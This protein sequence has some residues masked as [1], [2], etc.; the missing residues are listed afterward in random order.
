MTGAAGAPVVDGVLFDVD[1]TLV[2]TR[3]AFGEAVA[4]VRREFLPHVPAAR[5]P[6][7]LAV[8]R[9]DVHGHY[10][11]YT[12]GELGFDE[13]RRLRADELHVAL[14][15]P[16]V[17]VDLYPRWVEVFWGAFER[18]WEAHDDVAATLGALVAA[19]V[20]IGSVTNARV[21][22][23]ESKLA[24][25]GIDG[26]PVLVGVDTLGFGKPDPRVFLEA[27]RLLGT[28]PARTAYVGDEPDVDARAAAEAG[29]VGVWLDRPGIRREGPSAGSPDDAALPGVHRITGLHELHGVLGLA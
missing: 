24:T 15:G 25:A 5:E 21:A 6:E 3:A 14:G 23:Q 10:R 18:S 20:S 19:G 28:D 29:L 2:D 27:C 7:M 16:R 17:D 11:A 4:A 26:V 13:Q 12:R 8:W 1:D 9:D 22:L